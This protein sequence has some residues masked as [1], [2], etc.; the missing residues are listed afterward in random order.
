M[1]FSTP[2]YLRFSAIAAIMLVLLGL[3][4]CK[5]DKRAV[6]SAKGFEN[7]TAETTGIDF[8]NDVIEDSLINGVE[9]IYA[10]N[11]GGAATGDLNNDNLPD[12]I[13]NSNQQGP[14]VYINKGD[15]KF[16]KLE[17]FSNLFS[18][19][20]WFTGV[21][22]ADVNGDGRNDIY[23][24]KAGF[25]RDRRNLLFINKGNLQFTEQAAQYNLDDSNATSQAVFFDFD[26]DGDLDCYIANHSDYLGPLVYNVIH[27]SDTSKFSSGQNRFLLN[28]G[29]SFTDI[30]ATSG[31]TPKISYSLSVAMCDINYDGYPDLYVANDFLSPDNIYINDGG[32][33]FIDKTAE[34][35]PKTSLFSMGSDWGDLNGD[36]YFD[37]IAV[38]MLPDNHYRLK[39]N[40]LPLSF[41]LYKSIHTNI[42]PRQYIKNSVYL[43]GQ[44]P[45]FPEVAYLTGMARTDWSWSPLIQDFDNDGLNDV[46]VTNG[47]K[48]DLFNLDFINL[49]DSPDDP[50]GFAHNADLYKQMPETKL[51]N[52]LFKNKGNLQF[53][54]IAG[55]SEIGAP[56]TSSGAAYADFDNDGDLDLVVNNS[57]AQASVFKNKTREDEHKHYISIRLKST[58]DKNTN[59]IGSVVKINSGNHTQALQVSNSKGYASTSDNA[60]FFGLGEIN[61][62]DSIE[63]FW[64]N[65]SRQVMYNPVVDSAYIVSISAN[66][67]AGIYKPKSNI[68]A[69]F[70]QDEKSTVITH[71]ES[72]H[73]DFKFERLL[74]FRLS[75]QGP[76]IASKDLNND[77][78][79]DIVLGQGKGYGLQV[80]LQNRSGGFTRLTSSVFD[81][82][83][84]SD[85]TAICLADIDNNNTI[86]IITGYGSNETKCDNYT[87]VYLNNGKS[88]FTK[89]T[90]QT[91]FEASV[92]NISAFDFDGDNDLDLFL[93]GRLLPGNY[94]SKPSSA[95]WINEKGLFKDMST[96]VCPQLKNIGNVTGASITDFNGDRK[97]DIVLSGEFIPLAFFENKQG[98]LQPVAL[99]GVL[100]K[101]QGMWQGLNSGDFDNDGDIDFI[102]LN[103]GL[104]TYLP[105]STD[106]PITV[107]RGDYDN[108]GNKEPLLYYNLNGYNGILYDRNIF[109]EQMPMFWKKYFT[110]KQFSKCSPNELFTDEQ[111]KNAEKFTASTFKTC[112]IENKGNNKFEIKELPVEVQYST[113][114]ASLVDD[115][116]G[117][118]LLDIAITGN[119]DFDFYPY[120]KSDG[121]KGLILLNTGKLNFS[122]LQGKESGFYDPKNGRC[123]TKVKIANSN[124]YWMVVSNNNDALGFYKY[125]QGTN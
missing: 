11:G 45:P 96:Q 67:V 81:A 90:N 74:P 76:Q 109:C 38:D 53:D 17:S 77:G 19:T 92:S 108:N 24:S 39:N 85:V 93:G 18:H 97:P 61:K 54:N 113:A 68:V 32:K 102:A 22:I 42:S 65:R 118:G 28:D 95:I 60:L 12:V 3:T 94:P 1:Q 121:Y 100:A 89:A 9:Y 104:N 13:F 55:Q 56:I 79:E 43:G 6:K 78:L 106:K 117:D 47:T 87:N 105:A 33:K 10:Y 125:M 86:D 122:A 27:Y 75:E 91:I 37:L 83:T 120:G 70:Q 16:E 30:T 25:N 57:D 111:L 4:S 69:L 14:S 31:L 20:G 119:G 112:L 116:N 123:I 5:P 51:A 8:R 80:W 59:A 66:N 64:H 58:I 124:N 114:T 72:S 71:H 82:D 23:I 110:F 107:L 115:F 2:T 7:L 62:I 49:N 15:M 41:E 44:Y 21:N 40:F 98:K 46:F 84:L 26:L 36:G 35:L 29:N 52:Y 50:K 34:Y 48:R 73:N 88:Q 101:A 63:I 99:T 103:K